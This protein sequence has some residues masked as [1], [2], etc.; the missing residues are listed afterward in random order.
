M[1]VKRYRAENMSEAIAQV[2]RDLGPDAVILSTKT[3]RVGLTGP[4]KPLLEVAAAAPIGHMAPTP[5]PAGPSP[6][7]VKPTLPVA[8]MTSYREAERLSGGGPAVAPAVAAPAKS[9]APR[10]RPSSAGIGDA[11]DAVRI[12]MDEL[13]RK[14]GEAGEGDAARGLLNEMKSIA[15]E[16]TRLRQALDEMKTTRREVPADAREAVLGRSGRVVLPADGIPG[17]MARALL[18]AGLSEDLAWRLIGEVVRRIETDGRALADD[19]FDLLAALIM[20]RVRVTGTLWRV[21]RRG[22]AVAL[23]GPTGVGKTTTIAKIASQQVFDYGHRIALVTLDTFRVGAVDQLAAYAK[24]LSCPC[25]AAYNEKEFD[26]LLRV[27]ADK[28]LI[29]VDTVGISQR[30][31]E[32]M[33]RMARVFRAVG[34]VEP[35]LILSATTREAE[36]RDALERFRAVPIHSLVLSKLDETVRFGALLSFLEETDLPLSYF[37]VG[38]KVPEDIEVATPE[39]VADMILRV[40]AQ[41]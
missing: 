10:P 9:T 35:H 37:T 40:S 1:K 36:A 12:D 15:E 11:L 6:A 7:A 14:A 8:A 27:H 17:E 20:E 25:D 16:V 3:V 39:R 13:R 30:D 18:A 2:K 41:G 5:R 21:P 24:I 4:R 31:Q 19:G 38:Q 22:R 32:M 26:A 29:L 33:E 23:V 28:D 34:D